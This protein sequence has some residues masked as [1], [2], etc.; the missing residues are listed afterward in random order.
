MPRYYVTFSTSAFYT[1]EVEA[2]SAEDA[3]ERAWSY[4]APQPCC[5]EEFELSG[6]WDLNSVDKAED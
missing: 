2:E 4:G 6:E 5:Q 3:A 1:L